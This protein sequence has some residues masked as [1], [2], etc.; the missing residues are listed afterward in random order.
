MEATAERPRFYC[1]SAR[2]GQKQLP[3]STPVLR[4]RVEMLGSRFDDR[5]LWPSNFFKNLDCYIAGD[6]PVDGCDLELQASPG[7]TRHGARTRLVLMGKGGDSNEG[8]GLG[9]CLCRA[10]SRG[11]MLPIGVALT[12]SLE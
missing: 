1:T 8:W 3:T 9:R 12:V 7:L 2:R 10:Q 5:R 6:S 11:Q 4:I